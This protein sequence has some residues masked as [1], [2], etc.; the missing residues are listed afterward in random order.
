MQH[1]MEHDIAHMCSCRCRFLISRVGCFAQLATRL[2]EPLEKAGAAELGGGLR[3]PPT[4]HWC[5]ELVFP[6]TST[7]G[8]SGLALP[9]LLRLGAR[10]LHCAVALRGLLPA[11]AWAW[12]FVDLFVLTLWLCSTWSSTCW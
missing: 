9:G 3:V 12:F 7:S 11:G 10:A 5:A 6:W 1:G 2:S 4:S 8:S